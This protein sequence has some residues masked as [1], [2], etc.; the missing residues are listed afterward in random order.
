M[1]SGTFRLHA[2]VPERD[3]IRRHALECDQPGREA[4]PRHRNDDLNRDFL[5]LR[6][7][8]QQRVP[9]AVERLVPSAHRAEVARRQLANRSIRRHGVDGAEREQAR[10]VVDA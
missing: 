1:T 8:Q 4:F 10:P 2:M 5:A 7:R 3:A 9:A 6:A